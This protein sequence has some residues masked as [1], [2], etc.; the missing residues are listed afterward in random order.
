MAYQ[1]MFIFPS[2]FQKPEGIFLWYLLWAS[3]RAMGSKSHSIVR[4]PRSDCVPP[5]VFNSQS[6]PQG[7]SS[8]WSVHIFL[9]WHC[10]QRCFL[11]ASLCSVSGIG[12][13]RA[14]S[15]KQMPDPFKELFQELLA[16][17]AYISKAQ[18]VPP[19]HP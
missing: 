3:G 12:T 6:C 5:G 10:F 2:P 14:K 19:A 13:G 9:S 1:K 15:K 4:T 16:P 11:L 18:T 7:D 8:S 17:P